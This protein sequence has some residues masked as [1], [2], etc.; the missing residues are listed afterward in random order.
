[1]PAGYGCRCETCYWHRLFR[2]RAEINVKCFRG[3]ELRVRFREFAAWLVSRQGPKRAVR[4]LNRYVEFFKVI[5]DQWGEIP[6]AREL[7]RHFGP[8][9]VRRC[10]L[11]TQW[12]SE[13]YLEVVD[14]LVG[15]EQ[16]ERRQIHALIRK[17]P[18]GSDHRAL[19]ESYLKYL[20][21]R[22]S[23]RGIKLRSVRR[24]LSPAVDL[25]VASR[26]YP[27]QRD[28]DKYL[29]RKPGQRAALTGF[30]TYLRKEFGLNLKMTPEPGGRAKRARLE[31]RMLALMAMERCSEAIAREWAF[32]GLAYFHNVAA[33]RA[34]RP[35]MVQHEDGSQTV[36][37][38]GRVYWIPPRQSTTR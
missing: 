16:S 4:K 36:R 6:N 19:G 37:L 15:E 38:M 1:M 31:K 29:C 14:Q 26:S 34:G 24:S 20:E 11:V 5:E 12:L 21:Q 3:S 2:K 18:E 23:Q 33:G 10:R 32:L 8:E 35:A 22:R 30:V 27:S 17:L 9:G 13:V 25:L 28:V 7:V